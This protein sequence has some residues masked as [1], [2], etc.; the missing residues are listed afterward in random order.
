MTDFTHYLPAGTSAAERLNTPTECGH[1]GRSGLKVTVKMVDPGGATVWMGTGC[2][3]KALG[4]PAAEFNA[5][6]KTADLKAET[7]EQAAR[8]VEADAT[9]AAWK[10]FLDSAAGPGDTIDQLRRLGG[11]AAARAAYRD[12][13]TNRAND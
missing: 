9:H 5:L 8:R 11:Y 13:P 2:A 6:R 10:A 3:A 1:C 12:S 4:I 7:A